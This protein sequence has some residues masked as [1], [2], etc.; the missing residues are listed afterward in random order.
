MN[1]DVALALASVPEPARAAVHALWALDEALGRVLATGREP[2]ISRIRLAWWREALERLDREP[3]PKEPVLEGLA[4]NVLPRGIRGAEL[5][6]MEPGWA[7]LPGDEPITREDLDA[8][9]AARGALLFRFTARLLGGGVDVG[10]AGEAWALVDLAR[11][12]TEATDAEAALAAARERPLPRRWPKAL[13][14]LGMLAALTKRDLERG[15]A[16]WEEPGS[17]P[18]AARMMRHRLTGI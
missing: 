9:A 18:R 8:Y 13:R 12:S 17:P 7:L 16:R 6:E 10:L 4:R 5:A 11:H 14:P 15:P 2:M 1:A 3:P